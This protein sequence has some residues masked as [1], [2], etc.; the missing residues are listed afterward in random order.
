MTFFPFGKV[1]SRPPQVNSWKKIPC[2]VETIDFF[3][4]ILLLIFIGGGWNVDISPPWKRLCVVI[5]RGEYILPIWKPTENSG[6]CKACSPL[7]MGSTA[8]M[9]A[10]LRGREIPCTV[11]SFDFERKTHYCARKFKQAARIFLIDTQPIQVPLP[12]LIWNSNPPLV[13]FEYVGMDVLMLA[14]S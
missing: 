13:T 3:Y 2:P 7:G 4:R 1:V 8:R 5:R 6:G 11:H 9:Q 14:Q 10:H 12:S